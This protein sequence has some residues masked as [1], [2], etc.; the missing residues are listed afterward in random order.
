M[1][2]FAL[3]LV[4]FA[5]SASAAQAQLVC[6]TNVNRDPRLASTSVAVTSRDGKTSVSVV[7]QGGMAHFVTAPRKFDVTVAHE[8]PE[9]AIFSNSDE[10]FELT[11]NYEPFG[12]EIRGTLVTEVF[13]ERLDAPVVC[14]L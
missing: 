11:V 6:T 8:G 7:T 3:S 2:T 1:K 14:N 13:G 10:G 12:G 5:L 9:V 4:A